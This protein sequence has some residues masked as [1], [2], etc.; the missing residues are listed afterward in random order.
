MTPLHH[1]AAFATAEA[2][3]ALLTEKGE[4]AWK[5][6]AGWTPLHYAAAHGNMAT[7]AALIEAGAEVD[8]KT[9][10]GGLTP[11]HLSA[12]EGHLECV[13]ALLAKGASKDLD[14]NVRAVSKPPAAACLSSLIA[15]VSEQ[16][17]I[18]A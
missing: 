1:A 3:G 13:K 8:A 18:C 11:L 16:S 17:K 7:L 15:I 14:T 10:D 2:L 5:D 4:E 6:G 12:R 9:T